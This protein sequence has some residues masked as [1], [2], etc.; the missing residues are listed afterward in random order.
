MVWPHSRVQQP[1]SIH[2]WRRLWMWYLPN[3][4]CVSKRRQPSHRCP[5]A[6]GQSQSDGP[7]KRP[8]L[9]QVSLSTGYLWGFLKLGLKQVKHKLHMHTSSHKVTSSRHPWSTA[10]AHKESQGHIKWASMEHRT[11]LGYQRHTSKVELTNAFL[12]TMVTG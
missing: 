5:K 2:R 11:V 10:H 1:I 4:G 3:K 7:R 8:D 6:T 9:V 12:D